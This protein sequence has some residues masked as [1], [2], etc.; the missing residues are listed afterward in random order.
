MASSF[1]AWNAKDGKLTADNTLEI[2][3]LRRRL[4]CQQRRLDG[5][6]KQMMKRGVFYL[7]LGMPDGYS[8]LKPTEMRTP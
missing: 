4:K 6:A 5:L 8:M 7:G 3:E 1:E 2:S